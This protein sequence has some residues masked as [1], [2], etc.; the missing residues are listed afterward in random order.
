MDNSADEAEIAKLMGELV[1]AMDNSADDAEI[2]SLRDVAAAFATAYN[3]RTSATAAATAA[4]D[5]V[6]A[7]TEASGKITTR[8]PGVAGNSATAEANAQAVLDRPNR[9]KQCR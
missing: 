4:T 3:A 8:A 7:A 1:T 2:V 5:A 6:T 9:C